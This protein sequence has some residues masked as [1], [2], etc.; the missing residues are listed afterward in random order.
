[1]G[2]TGVLIRSRYDIY[3]FVH[4]IINHILYFQSPPKPAFGQGPVHKPWS[5]LPVSDIP[6][7]IQRNG[8]V[9]SFDD[10][11]FGVVGYIIML[12]LGIFKITK[13][14]YKYETLHKQFMNP[15]GDKS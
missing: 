12:C 9:G 15:Y 6:P 1:M 13:I 7:G 10:T 2:Y 11:F 5:S 4:C 14:K 3:L 8:S